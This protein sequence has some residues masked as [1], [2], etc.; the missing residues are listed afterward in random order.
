[1]ATQPTSAPAP[2]YVPGQLPPR[3]GASHRALR[4][5][6]ALEL[7][8]HALAADEPRGEGLAVVLWLV[9]ERLERHH[10]RPNHAILEEWDW[11][12]AA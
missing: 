10:L 8:L 4:A 7:E 9:R 3:D 2:F 11:R 5:M 12:C 1:M 6:V